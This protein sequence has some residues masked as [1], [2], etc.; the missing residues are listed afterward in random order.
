MDIYLR[1]IEETD[2]EDYRQ[3]ISQI[4]ATRYLTRF[5]PDEFLRNQK[6]RSEYHVWFIIQQG[7]QDAGTV[8]IQRNDATDGTV[9]LSIFLNSERKFG[10]RIGQTAIPQAI[11]KARAHLP[12]NRVLLNVR[13]N[14]RRAIACYQKCGFR[15]F[16]KHFKINHRFQFIRY[17][18]MVLETG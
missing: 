4:R 2:L 12:F 16:Q 11:E 1:H 8:W 6:I 3:W 15:I 10:Q 17:Y 18:S 9:K 13:R 14:N 5:Y 7:R